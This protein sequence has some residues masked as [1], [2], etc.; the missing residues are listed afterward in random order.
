[1]TKQRIILGVSS[2]GKMRAQCIEKHRRTAYN[3]RTPKV[4][5]NLHFKPMG[6]A[7]H[8]AGA[9]PISIPFHRGAVRY[10]WC[11][12]A[13]GPCGKTVQQVIYN[14]TTVVDC[15]YYRDDVRVV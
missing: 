6:Q 5:S 3:T 2:P 14:Q 15:C 11:P 1:M 4:R 10:G 12:V 8:V 13:L 7:V 9:M